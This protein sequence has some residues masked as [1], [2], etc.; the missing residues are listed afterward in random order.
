MSWHYQVRK[1]VLNQQP[2]FDI[3][4]KYSDPEG[5]TRESIAPGG[6]TY[7]ELLATLRHMVQDAQRYPWFEEKHG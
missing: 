2:Y 3:V 5:W 6:D 7:E 4:E 1:R